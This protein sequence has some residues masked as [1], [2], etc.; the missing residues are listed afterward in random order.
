MGDIMDTKRKAVP[1]TDEER[2]AEEQF[3]F[4]LGIALQQARIRTPYTQVDIA[5][6]IHVSPNTMSHYEGGTAKL[7]VFQFKILCDILRI[8]PNSFLGWNT[9]EQTSTDLKIQAKVMEMTKE[10]KDKLLSILDI[11]FP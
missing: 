11:I 2:K 10:D 8:S 1:K 5:K 9:T 4:D 7:N 6:K 3:F